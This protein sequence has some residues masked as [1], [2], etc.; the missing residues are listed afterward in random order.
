[1]D[2][3][4]SPEREVAFEKKPEHIVAAALD[5]QGEIYTGRTHADALNALEEVY[6]DWADMDVK[7]PRDGFMTSAGRFVERD[8]AGEIADKAGQLDALGSHSKQRRSS[9]YL[10]SHDINLN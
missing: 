3:F 5:F 7:S 6:P 10:D 4:H 8:E 1:M 9:E 2:G